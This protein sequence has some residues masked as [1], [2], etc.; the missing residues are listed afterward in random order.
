M[1]NDMY[2]A[3]LRYSASYSRRTRTCVCAAMYVYGA[4]DANFC[5]EDS[6][7]LMTVAACQSAAEDVGRTYDKTETH[8][9][10]P[11][12]CFLDIGKKKVDFNKNTTGAASP[13]AQ[14]LCKISGALAQPPT[15]APKGQSGVVPR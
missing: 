8:K 11:G 3:L 4:A 15:P 1:H 5:P 14:P 6:V 13:H 10:R 12:G 9:L 7:K 2:K